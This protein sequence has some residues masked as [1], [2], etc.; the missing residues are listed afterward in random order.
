M[1][2]VTPLSIMKLFQ[3]C[4]WLEPCNFEISNDQIIVRY[5]MDYLHLPPFF[6]IIVIVLDV[7]DM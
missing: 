2:A 6:F 1:T 3:R 4:N 7:I 5:R